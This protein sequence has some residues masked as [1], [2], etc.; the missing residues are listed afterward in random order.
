[1]T[2]G[3]RKVLIVPEAALRRNR[4][5]TRRG[6]AFCHLWGL[7]SNGDPLGITD[8]INRDASRISRALGQAPLPDA[9]KYGS[10]INGEPRNPTEFIAQLPSEVSET[11]RTG[12]DLLR[13]LPGQVTEDL[14]IA[15]NNPSAGA[16]Q[17]LVPLPREVGQELLHTPGFLAQRL[18][19]SNINSALAT[20]R[21]SANFRD[22]A[23]PGLLREKMRTIT[24]VIDLFTPT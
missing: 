5:G 19:P 6:P 3:G 20:V 1:M 4:G 17:A 15:L 14:T 8:A 2:S 18:A 12:L 10:S 11:A 24:D 9:S 23:D 13:R 22:V 7:E 16:G 21:D